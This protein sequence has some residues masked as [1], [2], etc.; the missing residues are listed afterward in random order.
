MTLFG[1]RAF[2]KVTK[3]KKVIWVS[4]DT[5]TGV[6]IFKRSGHKHTEER[7]CEDPRRRTAVYKPI[8]RVVLELLAFRT[9]RR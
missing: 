9:V 5:M 1:D 6:L 3:V 7:P 2:K 4:P 8:D